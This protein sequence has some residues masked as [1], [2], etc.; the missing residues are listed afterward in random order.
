LIV[1]LNMNEYKKIIFFKTHIEMFLPDPTYDQVV[2]FVGGM[3]YFSEKNF[4]DNFEKWLREKYEINSAF[5][6]GKLI[7]EINEKNFSKEMEG[8]SLIDFLLNQ[9]IEFLDD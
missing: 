4:L 1:I 3:S 2:A 8:R 7:K 6:W 5:Y 9:L